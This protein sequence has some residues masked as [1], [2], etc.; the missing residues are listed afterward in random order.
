MNTTYTGIKTMCCIKDGNRVYLPYMT[1]Y[2]CLFSGE[3]EAMDSLPRWSCSVRGWVLGSVASCD[4]TFHGK[5]PRTV[6]D[7]DAQNLKTKLG[8]NK[9]NWKNPNYRFVSRSRPTKAMP[10]LM[11]VGSPDSACCHRRWP[12]SDAMKGGD[13]SIRSQVKHN[14]LGRQTTKL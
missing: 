12:R 5:I 9:G 2:E 14:S 8:E 10:K 1:N 13:H 6:T 3:K 7:S 11:A 4:L